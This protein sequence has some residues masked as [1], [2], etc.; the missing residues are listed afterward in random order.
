MALSSP[1]IAQGKFAFWRDVVKGAIRPVDHPV[2][3][4]LTS[5]Q[6]HFQLS[7]ARLLQVIDAKVPSRPSSPGWHSKLGGRLL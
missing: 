7:P 5:I 1:A 4:A 2:A 6:S 3:G